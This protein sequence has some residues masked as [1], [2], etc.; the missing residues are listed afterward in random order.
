MLCELHRGCIGDRDGSSMMAYFRYTAT[1]EAYGILIHDTQQRRSYSMREMPNGCCQNLNPITM[2]QDTHQTHNYQR[3][4]PIRVLSHGS[5]I[6]AECF[7]SK[8][9]YPRRPPTVTHREKKLPDNI[10]TLNAGN[11]NELMLCELRTYYV[12]TSKWK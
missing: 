5:N 12:H 10:L 2:L 7:L 3:C 11:E 6:L 1:R 8:T 9:T 4:Y